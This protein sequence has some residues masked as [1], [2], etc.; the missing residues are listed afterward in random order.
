MED[1]TRGIFRHLCYEGTKIGT[2]IA[3]NNF[4]LMVLRNFKCC[5]KQLQAI[6]FIGPY[7]RFEPSY[8]FGVLYID[9]THVQ[10]SSPNDFEPTLG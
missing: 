7:Q 6:P 4:W 5:A 2:E 10:T 8:L 9:W 1:H 3:A